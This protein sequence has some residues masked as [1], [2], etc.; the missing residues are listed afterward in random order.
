MFPFLGQNF[1]PDVD[2]G[3]IKLHVRAQTG[4]RIEEVNRTINGIEKVVREIIPPDRLTGIVDNIGMPTSGLNIAYGNSGTIGVGDA[5]IL[6]SLKEGETPTSEYVRTMREVLPAKFAGTT[7][8]FLPADIVSQILNF[9]APAPLDV[10]IVGNDLN[11]NRDFTTKL[12]AKIRRVPGVADARVQQA[13][14][15]PAL[16]VDVDRSLASMVGLTEKD[17]TTSIQNSLAGSAQSSPTFYLDPRN[18]VSYPI[19]VQT[20]QYRMDTLNNLRN[21]PIVANDGNQVL[22]GVAKIDLQPT[23]AVISHLNVRPVIDIFATVQDRDLGAV[24]GEIQTIVDNMKG[25]A[26]KG[27]HVEL[28]GQV[29]IMHTAYSELFFGLAF[30]IVLIYLLIVVTFQS[31]VDPFLIVLGLPTALA[32]IVWMLFL[33]GTTLSV[34]A[35]TGAI[36]CM[37]VATANSILIISFARE[38]LTDGAD[39]FGAAIEA[40]AVRFRPVMMTALAMIIG[41]APMAI[42]HDSNSPLGRAVIGGL[43]FATFATLFFVPTLFSLAHRNAHL[44]SKNTTHVASAT[45]AHA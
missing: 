31:W 37:G 6:I 21:L 19:A 23:S 42:E 14:R 33:T 44:V 45:P 4:T 25:D 41:M 27:T 13:F 17:A 34:P 29:S 43:M 28:H 5:D 24:A 16:G 39:A 26:P 11:A 30:A 22:G 9:G 10:Q 40:G 35:L 18:G 2:S 12:I 8:A 15:A 1:F 38:R 32:G 36:M 7:F 20:P 3:A